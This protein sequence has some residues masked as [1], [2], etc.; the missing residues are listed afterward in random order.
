MI[1]FPADSSFPVVSSHLMAKAVAVA[2][3]DD[4]WLQGSSRDQTKFDRL[5]AIGEKDTGVTTKIK[6]MMMMM[7]IVILFFMYLLSLIDL[8]T[9]K[10]YLDFSVLTKICK[11]I[12]WN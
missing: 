7:I 11:V 8:L 3:L 5:S 12:L 9:S 1:I 2:I 10:I 6:V 4:Y